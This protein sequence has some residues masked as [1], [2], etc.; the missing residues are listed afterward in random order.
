MR[1]DCRESGG[2]SSCNE[3]ARLPTELEGGWSR[4]NEITDHVLH[5][6]G[7]PTLKIQTLQSPDVP[8]W[9]TLISHKIPSGLALPGRIT[10]PHYANIVERS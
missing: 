3:G 7:N 10:S 8:T 6:P 5:L 1:V 9:D 2:T 4:R